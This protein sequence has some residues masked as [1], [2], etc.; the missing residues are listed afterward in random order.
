MPDPTTP[1]PLA[2][3]V[4]PL[5]EA[6][7]SSINEFIQSRLDDIFNKPPLLLSDDDLRQA[8]MYYR[9]ERQRFMTE[10]LTKAAKGPTG[11]R[12]KVPKSVAEALASAEDLLE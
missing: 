5:G 2:P 4:S 12:K 3:N 9:Q 8:V 7:P 6:D 11:P 1:S 10:S